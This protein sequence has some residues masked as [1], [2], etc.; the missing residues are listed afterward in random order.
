MSV[1]TAMLE[2]IDDQLTRLK[3]NLDKLESRPQWIQANVLKRVMGWVP[4]LEDLDKK[5]VEYGQSVSNLS[6]DWVKPTFGDHGSKS[7]ALHGFSKV[8][9]FWSKLPT[10]HQE[11]DQQTEIRQKMAKKMTDQMTRVIGMSDTVVNGVDT[12]A[13]DMK[14]RVGNFTLKTMQRSLGKLVDGKHVF[15]KRMK[16]WNETLTSMAANTHSSAD[17]AEFSEAAS[18]LSDDALNI[19]ESVVKPFKK[20]FSSLRMS[21]ERYGKKAVKDA[22]DTTKKVKKTVKDVSDVLEKVGKFQKGM[23]AIQDNMRDRFQHARNAR[24]QADKS[25]R[26]GIFR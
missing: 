16:L 26:H 23:D 3:T 5:V 12:M 15:D 14:W 24:K 7:D 2:D 20:S 9:H 19:F 8:L 11:V 22:V 4:A 13:D 10:K 25:V 21:K 18:K 17:V 6:W 1:S